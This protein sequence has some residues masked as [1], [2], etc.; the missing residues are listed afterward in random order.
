M[1]MPSQEGGGGEHAGTAKSFARG[2]VSLRAKSSCIMDGFVRYV[3]T[4]DG[5]W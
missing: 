3:A 2:P 1:K 5:I 4:T